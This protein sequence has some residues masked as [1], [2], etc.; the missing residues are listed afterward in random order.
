M[1]STPRLPETYGKRGVYIV[2]ACK[3]GGARI[4]PYKLHY[5]KFMTEIVTC[6]M[7]IPSTILSIAK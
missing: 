5:N 4:F 1:I 2:F 6:V 3:N 7:I